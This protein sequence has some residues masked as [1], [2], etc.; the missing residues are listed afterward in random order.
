MSCRVHCLNWNPYLKIIIRTCGCTSS[1]GF[2]RDIVLDIYVKSKQCADLSNKIRR[3]RCNSIRDALDYGELE[4]KIKVQFPCTSGKN[5]LKID[6]IYSIM[7]AILDIIVSTIF[8]TYVTTCR[9]CFKLY[10]DDR[11]VRK[12]VIVI[13]IVSFMKFIL[14]VF[15]YMKAH[16]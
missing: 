3:I 6:G 16:L 1:S 9:R 12:S 5:M 2:Y 11:S 14:S 15:V 13:N 10:D 7:I 4:K 8:I